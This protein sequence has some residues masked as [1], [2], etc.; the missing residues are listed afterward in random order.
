MNREALKKL[1]TGPVATVPTPFDD[2]FQIDYGRI[3]VCLWK[4]VGCN[5]R[6]VCN[7]H[8]EVIYHARM[9]DFRFKVETA[10]L[11]SGM[12]H[13]QQLGDLGL[14]IIQ[15]F[16]Q[17]SQSLGSQSADETDRRR[18]DLNAQSSYI[19]GVFFSEFCDN[20]F[21]HVPSVTH[22]GRCA[23]AAGQEHCP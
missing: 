16:F 15:D 8:T 23:D 18:L 17:V 9:E 14:G 21:N 13:G 22:V 1:I 7:F 6:D 3:R 10:S 4:A 2:E 19:Q 5:L 20:M 11:L 12:R